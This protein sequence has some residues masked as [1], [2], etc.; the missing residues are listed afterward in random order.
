MGN[1]AASVAAA[2]AGLAG[3]FVVFLLMR[4]VWCWYWK[5]NAGM[6]ELKAIRAL[7]EQL[8]QQGAAQLQL[9][10]ATASAPQTDKVPAWQS[11]VFK[12]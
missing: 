3:A 6:A 2:I 7:L 4:E 8:T 10:R 12:P 11:G 5:I 1:A 9:A